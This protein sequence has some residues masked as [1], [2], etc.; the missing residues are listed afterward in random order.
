MWIG[1]RISPSLLHSGLEGALGVV[2]IQPFNSDNELLENFT[3]W[4]NTLKVDDLPVH[5]W[6]TE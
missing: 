1:T 6:T 4:L 3:L 2:Q 5:K